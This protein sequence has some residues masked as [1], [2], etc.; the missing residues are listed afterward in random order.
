M[1]TCLR[2]NLVHRRGRYIQ[3]RRNVGLIRARLSCRV[4]EHKTTRHPVWLSQFNST[5]RDAT[6]K[7]SFSRVYLS[8]VISLSPSPSRER[9]SRIIPFTIQGPGVVN[10]LVKRLSEIYF[11]NLEESSTRLDFTDGWIG[12]SA[13][14]RTF[15]FAISNF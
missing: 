15:F 1:S 5:I 4:C 13:D 2:S 14:E 6:R 11:S 7:P 12:I 3:R 8:S 10:Q 9:D